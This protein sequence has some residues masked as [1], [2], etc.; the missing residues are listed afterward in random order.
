M[1]TYSWWAQSNEGLLVLTLPEAV[2]ILNREIERFAIE[3][4]YTTLEKLAFV[5][6]EILNHSCKRSN[7]R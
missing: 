2:V 3:Q 5:K 6:R 7:K 4:D 1:Q